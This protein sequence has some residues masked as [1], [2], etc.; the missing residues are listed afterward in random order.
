MTNEENHSQAPQNKTLENQI[1]EGEVARV[2]RHAT[3]KER[4]NKT[5]S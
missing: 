1:L 4:N 2:K 3:F 5:D